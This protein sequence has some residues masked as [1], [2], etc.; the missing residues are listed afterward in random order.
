MFIAGK[1]ESEVVF[2]EGKRAVFNFRI[3]FVIFILKL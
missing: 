3:W 1:R 2:I